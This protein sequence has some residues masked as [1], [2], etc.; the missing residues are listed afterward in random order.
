MSLDPGGNVEPMVRLSGR[1]V[2]RVRV[3]RIHE[4]ARRYSGGAESLVVLDGL[5][6]GHA[7]VL[8]TDGE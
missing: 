8:G 7:E 6:R 2:E 1:L 5:R 3:F 4:H